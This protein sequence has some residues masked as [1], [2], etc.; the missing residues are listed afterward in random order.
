MP[1]TRLSASKPVIPFGTVLRAGIRQN[2]GMEPFRHAMHVFK[3][4]IAASLVGLITFFWGMTGHEST[5]E[6]MGAVLG[7][8]GIVVA[9][10]GRL[11][12][13]DEERESLDREDD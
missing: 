1:A 3:S 8:S 10:V 5:L 7:F 12:M 11:L 6:V 9:I 2:R 4:G 13:S